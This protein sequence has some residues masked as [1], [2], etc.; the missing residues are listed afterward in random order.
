MFGIGSDGEQRLGGGAEEN[1]VDDALVLVG[2]GG[3]LFGEGEDDVEIP[4]GQQ[5]ALARLRATRRGPVTGTWGNA[6]SGR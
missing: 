5:F 3:N 4:D 6:G 1:A 2:D